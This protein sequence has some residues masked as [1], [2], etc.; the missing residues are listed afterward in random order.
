M[1]MSL[2]GIAMTSL[3]IWLMLLTANGNSQS[4]QIIC[5]EEPSCHFLLDSAYRSEQISFW[6]TPSLDT[7]YHHIVLS[8]GETFQKVVVNWYA[9]RSFDYRIDSWPQAIWPQKQVPGSPGA[10]ISWTSTGTLEMA[11]PLPLAS[12]YY[13][14]PELSWNYP[15]RYTPAGASLAITRILPYNF[16]A[17]AELQTTFM[18]LYNSAIR[19]NGISVRIDLG[20]S[21]IWNGITLRQ[22]GE[23]NIP[24]WRAQGITGCFWSWNP[25]TMGIEFHFGDTLRLGPVLV[26]HLSPEFDIRATSS[27]I[28]TND[29]HNMELRLD[30]R[31]IP[32]R[33]PTPQRSPRRIT[34]IAAKVY[35]ASAVADTGITAS[36]IEFA[37]H[38]NDLPPKSPW[39]AWMRHLRE[40]PIHYTTRCPTHYDMKAG[41]CLRPHCDEWLRDEHSSPTLVQ[42]GSAEFEADCSVLADFIRYGKDLGLSG[43]Y[44]HWRQLD[45]F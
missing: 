30:A 43:S 14:T 8:H 35:L 28:W 1:E 23:M 21:W 38:E 5:H 44:R 42:G 11:S 10:L 37:Y 9:E 6:E 3:V 39:Q 20:K 7:G 22:S 32:S 40:E 15:N 17:E 33:I 19:R 29:Y 26:G 12:Q 27:I 24:Y 18:S 4:L 36:Q 34:P 2:K 31:W 25:V 16:H 45:S 13:V 41:I